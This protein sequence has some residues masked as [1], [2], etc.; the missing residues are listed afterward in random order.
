M[1]YKELKAIQVEI[2]TTKIALNLLKVTFGKREEV[3][4]MGRLGHFDK[5]N[6]EFL[7]DIVYVY[8]KL[9]F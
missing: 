6:L 5:E 2:E 3:E 8:V 1:R 7:V 4:G 9:D